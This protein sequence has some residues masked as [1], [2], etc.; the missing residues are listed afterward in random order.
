MDAREFLSRPMQANNRLRR[1]QEKVAA[2]KSLTERVTTKFGLDSEPVSHSRNISGMQDTIIQL[3][4]AKEEEQRLKE[5]LAAVEL[6]VGAVLA[7]LS[8]ERLY[9][10]MVNRYMDFMTIEAAANEV[11]FSFSWGRLAVERGV[12]EVQAIIDGMEADGESE[13]E[14]SDLRDG[15]AV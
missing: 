15:S 11:G 14:D 1:A 3:S 9:D 8:D 2:L 7:K 13:P 4:E 5:E 10:F 12:A 6:K